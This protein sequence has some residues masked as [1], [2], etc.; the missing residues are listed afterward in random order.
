[1]SVSE[2]LKEAIDRDDFDSFKLRLCQ[3]PLLDEAGLDTCLVLAMPHCSLQIIKLLLQ[4]GA[5][6]KARSWCAIFRRGDP[7][8]FQLLIE[9]GWDIDSTEQE[10]SAVQ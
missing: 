9:S 6:L 10:R 7:A 1:M 4:L 3:E 5:E 2:T 8:V